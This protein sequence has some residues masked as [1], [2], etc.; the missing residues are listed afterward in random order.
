MKHIFGKVMK[1]NKNESKEEFSICMD[2]K[3]EFDN[4]AAG[5][6]GMAKYDNLL[7]LVQ[8]AREQEKRYGEPPCEE[9]TGYLEEKLELF[10][11]ELCAMRKKKVE[12]MNPDGSVDAKARELI[13]KLKKDEDISETILRIY[14]YLL[15]NWELV[16]GYQVTYKV[17]FG[18]TV[19]RGNWKSSSSDRKAYDKILR[20]VKDEQKSMGFV[21]VRND[22]DENH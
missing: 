14:D 17:L 2:L 21:W 11:R 7:P 4:N 19:I 22:E 1:N 13:G 3:K 8:F 12:I 10:G 5:I 15:E 20:F 9:K 6:K 16:K 18:L